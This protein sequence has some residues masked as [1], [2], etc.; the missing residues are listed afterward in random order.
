MRKVSIIISILF[1]ISTSLTLGFGTYFLITY[2]RRS[3]NK[4]FEAAYIYDTTFSTSVNVDL[5]LLEAGKTK[6]MSI[7]IVSLVNYKVDVEISIRGDENDFNYYI[8]VSFDDQNEKKTV[9][10]YINGNLKYTFRLAQEE[11]RDVHVYY[12]LT[13]EDAVGDT[14]F[15]VFIKA[16]DVSRAIIETE[17]ETML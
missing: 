16:Q 5:G 9:S 3:E 7:P 14:N 12:S 8:N 4:K 15:S 2:F 10:E 17:K 1:I 6:D 11:S 13:K